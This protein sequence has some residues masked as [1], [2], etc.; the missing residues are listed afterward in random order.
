MIKKAA[1]I[2]III[3]FT[4]TSLSA[5]KKVRVSPEKSN[6]L[7]YGFNVNVTAV[8]YKYYSSILPGTLAKSL[9][10]KGLYDITIKDEKIIVPADIK[11]I[12]LKALALENPGIDF[13]IAGDFKIENDNPTIQLTIY[14]VA[15]EYFITITEENVE[16][17]ALLKKSTDSL[18]KKINSS[19]KGLIEKNRKLL[20][21]SPFFP[22]YRAL[23]NTSFG[24]NTGN[25]FLL[26]NWGDA[27]NHTWFVNPFI[28]ISTG[29]LLEGSGIQ[30]NA[31]YLS[32]ETRDNYLMN[33]SLMRIWNTTI[34]LSYSINFARHF[35]LSMLIGLGPS[36]TKI[37]YYD[38]SAGSG[39]DRLIM[40]INK[41]TELLIDASLCFNL[42]FSPVQ[43]EF[44]SSIKRI[45][46]DKNGIN[47]VTVFAGIRYNI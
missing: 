1:I 44:G 30:L 9:Q 39:P 35:G 4:V 26:G 29:I 36:F 41:N 15:G 21:P 14:N 45:F 20:A 7:L 47:F 12:R 38:P 2:F 33:N 19:I 34:D 17:K 11:D 18:S 46:Y 24:I 6:I 31:E 42:I 43:L 10:Q 40:G 5:E 8:K 3:L 23:S 22:L 37:T 13:I 32:T 16:T 28:F 25:V 27:Y